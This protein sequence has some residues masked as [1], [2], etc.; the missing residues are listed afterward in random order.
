MGRA[1]LIVVAGVLMS[2]GLTQTSLFGG[3]GSMIGHSG[4]YAENIQAKNIAIWAVN[5]LSKK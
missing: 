1:M 5:L 2:V 3:L 4:S